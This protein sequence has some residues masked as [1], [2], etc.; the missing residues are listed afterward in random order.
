MKEVTKKITR[1]GFTIVELLVVISIM[2]VIATLATGAVLK[3]VRQSRVKRMDM[4]AKS[5]E[6]AIMSYRALTGEWP[7]TVGAP[8]PVGSDVKQYGPEFAETRTFAGK[9]NAE[10]FE[11]IFKEVK[12]GR[13]LLD[14]SSLLTSTGRGRMSVREALDRGEKNIAV[15]YPDPNDQ[16]QFCYFKVIYNFQTDMVTVEKEK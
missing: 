15:G 10:V 4:M 16:R 5:L 13:P 3:S 8:D 12:E 9:K 2:A 7:F 11:N 6:S 1:R 14:T